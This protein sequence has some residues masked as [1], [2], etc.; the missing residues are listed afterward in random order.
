MKKI[1]LRY[2]NFLR[3][4]QFIKNV[5][6]WPKMT[7]LFIHKNSKNNPWY[8]PTNVVPKYSKFYWSISGKIKIIA[9]IKRETFV[10]RE[11][12]VQLKMSFNS[13][14]ISVD[15]IYLCNWPNLVVNICDLCNI[16]QG[17]PKKITTLRVAKYFWNQRTEL[18]TVLTYW[19]LKSMRKFWIQNHFCAI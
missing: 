17:V 11:N 5:S 12:N 18:L 10:F 4:L 7:F 19:K 16:I 14:I 8:N 2:A 15:G 13:E 6:V 1:R 3:K 9:T